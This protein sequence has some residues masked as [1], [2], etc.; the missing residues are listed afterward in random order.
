MKKAV[1]ITG[2]CGFIGANFIHH[3]RSTRPELEIINLDKL[4]YSGNPDN[5]KS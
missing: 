4:T 2:G 1:L 5:L 3:M